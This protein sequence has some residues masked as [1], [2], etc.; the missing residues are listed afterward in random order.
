MMSVTD[1]DNDNDMANP[2]NV[3]FG[4]DDTDDDLDEEDDEIYWKVNI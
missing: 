1:D 4:S 3:D 2:Y